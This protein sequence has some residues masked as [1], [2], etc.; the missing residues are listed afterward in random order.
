MQRY[1]VAVARF[2][3]HKPEVLCG[4]CP[5]PEIVTSGSVAD[6]AAK[7]A[8]DICNVGVNFKVQAVYLGEGL[9]HAVHICV[10]D[11][12]LYSLNVEEVE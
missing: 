9:P 7:Y 4:F 10:P 8:V 1:A 2:C 5:A 12:I 11:G 6:A 3:G